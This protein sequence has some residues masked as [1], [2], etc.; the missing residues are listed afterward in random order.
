[1]TPELK[2]AFGET[3]WDIDTTSA[4]A[5]E[6]MQLQRVTDRD[7][8]HYLRDFFNIPWPEFIEEPVDYDEA[9]A[10][11]EQYYNDIFGSNGDDTNG[12]DIAEG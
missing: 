1:M 11:M 4:I 7:S 3:L 6:Q 9:H 5:F 12:T 8:A 2:L 10:V